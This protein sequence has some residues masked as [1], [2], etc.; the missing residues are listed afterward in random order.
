[1][2]QEKSNNLFKGINENIK[3]I[4][5]NMVYQGISFIEI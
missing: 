3:V 4:A 5:H 1:M 2:E